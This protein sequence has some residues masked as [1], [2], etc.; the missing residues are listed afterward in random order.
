MV[1]N[2]Q[3]EILDQ[4]G[5][6]R[7]LQ[8]LATKV[9]KNEKSSGPY[10]LV[11]IHTRGI[12]LAKRLA[13]MLGRPEEEIGTLDINLY[14]DDL[15]RGTDLPEVRKTHLPFELDGSKI[16][17][18]DDVLFT[19]RTIRSALDALMDLGRP[20]KIELWVLIDRGGRELP[21][22]ADQAGK[23]VQAGP[24]EIVKVRLQET[25][26]V[27]QVLIVKKPMGRHAS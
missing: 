24:D 3:K 11:G 16:L 23:F 7:V 2:G 15:S 19:G 10:K 1:S 17:L 12:P 4:K 25:D 14:R 6:A 22:Q 8:E 26:G 9:S 5:L 27:D 13:A 18:V 20:E 21:I